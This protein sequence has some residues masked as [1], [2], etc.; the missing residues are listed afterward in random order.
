M[1]AK[2]KV[3]ADLI[4]N[5]CS[6]GLDSLAKNWEILDSGFIAFSRATIPAFCS[7]VN[8]ESSVGGS[9]KNAPIGWYRLLS[10]TFLVL[11]SKASGS[12]LPTLTKLTG[13]GE[14]T[15]RTKKVLSLGEGVDRLF[16]TIENSSSELLKI[17]EAE[18]L[19]SSIEIKLRKR[20]PVINFES[21]TVEGI[22]GTFCGTLA[23]RKLNFFNID[24]FCDKHNY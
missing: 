18:H 23:C 20:A 14:A 7:S 4:M 13:L 19:T 24:D 9:S 2:A 6:L 3:I 17:S 10:Q 16:A 21:E 5:P 11:L 15:R 12:P 1:T 8:P 22:V